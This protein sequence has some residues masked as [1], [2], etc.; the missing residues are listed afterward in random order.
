MTGKII[1]ATYTIGFSR[2]RSASEENQRAVIE[3]ARRVL[4]DKRQAAIEERC[5]EAKEQGLCL[6]VG[7]MEFPRETG[8]VTEL[9]VKQPYRFGTAE[10]D[11]PAGWLRYG[12]W[13]IT[14]EEAQ[15]A[16][17]LATM[18]RTPETVVPVGKLGVDSLALPV[19]IRK[20]PEW[21]ALLDN[22]EMVYAHSLTALQDV[23][24][25]YKQAGRRA[26]LHEHWNAEKGRWIDIASDGG[27]IDYQEQA[28][29]SPDGEAA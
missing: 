12:P 24:A 8:A 11:V 20:H 17:Q 3:D 6:F 1:E 13:P 25:V 28:G 9:S 4:A 26:E 21:S 18:T 27:E 22:F 10:E 5:R 29:N 7:P 19:G 23:C 14:A 15:R 2:N 16:A